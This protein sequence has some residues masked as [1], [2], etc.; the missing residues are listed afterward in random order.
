MLKNGMV[1]AA[2]LGASILVVGKAS[3]QTTGPDF[4]PSPERS[5]YDPD[6]DSQL[7]R[8][9]LRFQKRQI[10]AAN[11]TLTNAQ[12]QKFWPV[13]DQYEAELAHIG[14]Q[15]AALLKEYLR[16]DNAEGYFRG[17]AALEESI[18]Q[19]KLR[20]IPIFSK[21]LS[22]KGTALFFRIDWRLSQIIDLQMEPMPLTEP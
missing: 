4:L 5:F 3:A 19:V 21:I 15:K 11:M 13:Y 2:L 8:K 14:D 22:S 17:R 12:E 6:P 10:V 9:N 16:D 7:L 18:L 20:Y 1:A